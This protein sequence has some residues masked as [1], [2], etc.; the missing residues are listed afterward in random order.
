MQSLYELV[1]RM[2]R[3]LLWA[4][5][6]H[7]VLAVVCLVLLGTSA[8]PV[9]GVH[10]AL[11]PFKFAI[12]IA[13]FLATMGAPI[14][15][16]SISSTTKSVL[17]WV[18]L[19][20]MLA[21]MLPIMAQALRGTTSHFNVRGAANSVL[22]NVM[23]VAIVLATLAMGYVTFVATLRPLL[24]EAGLPIAPLMAFAWRAGLFLLLLTP[25]SGFAMGSRSQHSVGGPD[26][27]IGLPFVNW[28]VQYGDLRV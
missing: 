4:S 11:K 26:G 24:S 3:P 19:L 13:L 8:E 20:T 7:A 5:L 17:T 27:G 9:M 6:L 10:R 16:L 23:F 14:P 12:S 22:W 18:F 1:H 25:V 2:P 15:C 21:E 28:S